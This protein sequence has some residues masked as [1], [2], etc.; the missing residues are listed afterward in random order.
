MARCD[1][2]AAGASLEGIDSGTII[3][4]DMHV[5]DNTSGGAT[6]GG[7]VSGGMVSSGMVSCENAQV[8]GG[9]RD[10]NVFFHA[11]GVDM[12]DEGD[13]SSAGISAC[14]SGIRDLLICVEAESGCD[15]VAGAA[16]FSRDCGIDM[17]TSA[18]LRW[19]TSGIAAAAAAAAAA[20]TW[21]ERRLC[22]DCDSMDSMGVHD[23]APGTLSVSLPRRCS[24]VLCFKREKDR[25]RLYWGEGRGDEGGPGTECG[26]DPST[27]SGS[28]LG[29][30]WRGACKGTDDRGKSD[31]CEVRRSDV[32]RGGGCQISGIDEPPCVRDE[33]GGGKS[34]FD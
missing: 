16:V 5:G 1:C 19:G 31:E 10:V 28:T 32:D 12:C 7:S 6:S 3:A 11:I 13:I 14:D 21:T 27:R 23:M 29:A 15:R 17:G 18:Y 4:G 34:W 20:A 22:I 8:A 2:I 30:L 33:L 26:G 24:S 9:G 25:S